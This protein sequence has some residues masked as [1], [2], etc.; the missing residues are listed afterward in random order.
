MEFVKRNP[1]YE[2]NGIL[3]NDLVAL[4]NSED[5]EVE[6]DTTDS[7]YEPLQPDTYIRYRVMTALAFYRSRIPKYSRDRN[8]AQMFLVTGAISTG[9]LAFFSLSIWA[10]LVSIVTSTITAFLEFLGTNK[11]II[12]YSSTVDALH[13]LIIWWETLPRIDQSMVSNIDKLVTSC[14]DLIQRE[15]EAWKSTSQSVNLLKGQTNTRSDRDI[16]DD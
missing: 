12:R 2:I 4:L 3:L 15:Q 5:A 6:Q 7:H 9:L 13:N 16:E 10:I 1:S 8:I 14:E 11:K